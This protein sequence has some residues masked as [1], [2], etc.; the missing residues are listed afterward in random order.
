MRF[1]RDGITWWYGTPDAPAPRDVVLSGSEVRIRIGIQSSEEADVGVAYRVNGGPAKT[2][3]AQPISGG[4]GTYYE[5]SLGA[6]WPGE[7]VDYTVTPK[8]K[9]SRHAKR[10]EALHFASSFRVEDQHTLATDP[11][12]QGNP[13]GFRDRAPSRFG[14]STASHASGAI[15]GAAPDEP[16]GRFPRPQARAVDAARLISALSSSAADCM[17][18]AY[19]IQ[20][21]YTRQFFED[22][23]GGSTAASA[24]DRP[25]AVRERHLRNYL[26]EMMLVAPF[27]AER[28]ATELASNVD[29][30]PTTAAVAIGDRIVPLPMHVRDASQG[31]ALYSIPLGEAQA[32]LDA[33]QAPFRAFAASPERTLLAI[34]VVDYRDSDLGQYFELGAALG[35]T[36][37]DDPGAALGMFVLALPVSQAFSRDAGRQIWG[38]SKVLAP[39]LTISR[40]GSSVRCTVVQDDPSTFALTLPAGGYRRSSDVS[41]SPHGGLSRLPIGTSSEV[42]AVGYTLKEG[43][44]Q[45]VVITRIGEG[46]RLQVGGRVDLRLG[47]GDENNCPCGLVD[48]S[49]GAICLCL[50]L[51]RLKVPEKKPVACGWTERMSATLSAPQPLA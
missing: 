6:F 40:E 24:W 34:F 37:T 42:A 11:R 19:D 1:E 38:Y 48:R 46:E 21:R 7:I 47:A 3:S 13:A 43:G 8:R 51:Q 10:E 27:A 45:R 15:S 22:V 33:Q 17:R 39:G 9:G 44:S 20:V 35:V 2:L 30:G 5:A 23:L 25:P 31:L 4:N 41:V 26:T 32:V 36:P 50:L 18:R 28:L 16:R 29:A 14:G 12:G 49:V